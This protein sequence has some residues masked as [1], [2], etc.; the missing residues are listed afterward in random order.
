MLAACAGSSSRGDHNVKA[1]TVETLVAMGADV[2]A[3]S[4]VSGKVMVKDI[5]SDG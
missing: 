2:N 4:D 5:D 1:V 3:Q